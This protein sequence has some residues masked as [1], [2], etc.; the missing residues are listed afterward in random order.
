MLT[1]QI[2]QFLRIVRN[3]WCR[4]KNNEL[5][6]LVNKIFQLFLPK[7]HIIHISPVSAGSVN[8]TF[9]VETK[10]G[11]YICQRL[12]G[13]VFCEPTEN[14]AA[15]YEGYLEACKK[16]ASLVESWRAPLW[17]TQPL[18]PRQESKYFYKDDDGRMWRVYPMIEGLTYAATDDISIIRGFGD[19]VAKLHYI[20][21]HFCGVPKPTIRGFHSFSHYYEEYQKADAV[22]NRDAF[23]DEMIGKFPDFV[24]DYNLP[25]SKYVIHGDTKLG[26]IIF[27]NS[28]QAVAVIDL[29]TFSYGSRLIDIADS[30][31][32]IANVVKANAEGLQENCLDTDA[33]LT[34]LES[35]CGSKY[36]VLS[37]EEELHLG[38]AVLY[39]P[40]ELGLRYYT[41]YLN[42]SRYFTAGDPQRSLQ[43]AR[44]Q[45]YLL[46]AMVEQNLKEKVR[47]WIAANGEAR[48]KVKM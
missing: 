45:F 27:D 46:K 9:Q 5:T 40:F 31:R 21:N 42:G 11:K 35:Y 24:F 15:N 20:L 43:K 29:D 32:S 14:I 18:W 19:G 28:G 1:Y 16:T 39:M 12:S 8:S 2:V 34:F 30:I 10:A 38:E 41:D 48:G 47:E 33:V 6:T 23:C 13:K 25:A 3:I 26:N 22:K 17:L 37:E 4:M 44:G 7:E 36:Y